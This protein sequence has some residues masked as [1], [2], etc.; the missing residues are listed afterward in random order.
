MRTSPLIDELLLYLFDG[1]P[2]LL[3]EP[4]STWLARSRRFS[5][6]VSSFR[7]KIRKK[8]RVIRDEKT[9]FDLRLELETAYLLLREK[10]LMFSSSAWT[11]RA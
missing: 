11:R 3:A 8:L 4:M 5:D 2:H 7:N 1:K 9:L 6:F 10:T